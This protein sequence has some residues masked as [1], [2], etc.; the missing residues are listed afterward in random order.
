LAC[1]GYVKPPLKWS[2]KH[3][4]HLRKLSPSPITSASTTTTKRKHDLVISLDSRNPTPIQSVHNTPSEP[5]AKVSTLDVDGF[6]DFDTSFGAFDG[7]L[8]ASFEAGLNDFQH[9]FPILEQDVA[10]CPS[11]STMMQL[12]PTHVLDPYNWQ[13]SL[14][15]SPWPSQRPEEEFP[16]SCAEDVMHTSASGA[17]ARRSTSPKPVMRNGNEVVKQN[18]ST[19]SFISSASSTFSFLLAP[20]AGL[21]TT[22]MVLVEYYFAEVAGLFSCYDSAMNPFRTTVSRLW[23]SS[24][25]IY[26]TL[27]SMAAACLASSFPHLGLEGPLLRRRATQI[28]EAEGCWDDKSLLALLMLGQTASWHDPKDL[29]IGYFNKARSCLSSILARQSGS[30]TSQSSS[31]SPSS[32]P[33]AA[34]S[35]TSMTGA[36]ASLQASGAGAGAV[37]PNNVRFFQEALTYWEMLLAYVTDD[38]LLPEADTNSSSS[39]STSKHH[40]NPAG[41]SHPTCSTPPSGAASPASSASDRPIP[42]PWTGLAHPIHRT[43]H[44]IGSLIRRERRRQKSRALYPTPGPSNP[45]FST[46]SYESSLE[47]RAGRAALSQARRLEGRLLGFTEHLALGEEDVV[48]PGDGETPVWHLLRVAEVYRHVG[49]GVLWRGFPALRS[50]GGGM[51]RKIREGKLDEACGNGGCL[52]EG[53][54]GGMGG[55][56]GE[57]ES[58]RGGTGEQKGEN[59]RD[60][61]GEGDDQEV[62][63]TLALSALALLKSMPLESRTRCLQPFLLVALASELRYPSAGADGSTALP[64]SGTQG[65]DSET[66]MPRSL[67]DLEISQMR[68]FVLGRLTSFLHVLPPKPIGVCIELVRETWRRCDQAAPAGSLTGWGQGQGGATAPEAVWWVDVMMERGWE[69]MMG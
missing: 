31:A 8:D 35:P 24:P 3:E 59:S 20:T 22:T 36:G 32:S 42:H 56:G 44:Q 14:E 62:L 21:N 69:T 54:A 55:M 10:S 41:N 4:K 33:A 43:V 52:F 39:S 47:E 53:E 67:R 65:A 19:S 57:R 66:F 63:T 30:A 58:L 68:N 26:Y 64:P 50:S 37:T 46:H 61:G 11:G 51:R 17:W 13:T 12:T 38:F 16:S 45:Y 60:G 27:Q 49:V 9:A 5:A 1:P 40:I 2:T 6:F 28:L 34:G 15:I 48:S 7:P 23:D 29:G 25:A 18:P